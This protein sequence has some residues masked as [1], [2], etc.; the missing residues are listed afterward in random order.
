MRCSETGL[1]ENDLMNCLHMTRGK[2][3]MLAV[4]I[5][6]LALAGAGLGLKQRIQTQVKELFRMN[7]ELQEEGY[8]MADFEFKMMGMAYWLDHGHY[9]TA[10]TRLSQ[11][12]R[13]LKAKEGLV[14]VPAFS[15]KE[16]EL[17][18]Y[19]DFQNPKTGAFMDDTFPYCTYNEITENL[20][21]LL[22]ALAKETGQPL[23]LKY[24][25]KYLD[26]VNTP[27]K[28]RAF[29]DDTSHVG[30]VASRFPN[31]TFVLARSMLSFA[32]G[33]DVITENN[34]YNFSPEWRQALLQWF[35]DNQDSE[36]G[37]WGP[38][39][40][41]SG[42]LL[43]QDLTNTASVLKAFVDRTGSDI[44]ET[45][46]LRHRKEMARTSL[47]LLA[48]PSPAEQDLHEWHEWALKIGKGTYMLTRYLWKDASCEEKA[49]AKALIERF[50]TISFDMY[51]VAG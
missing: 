35:Y 30:W 7:K 9:Y 38:R 14:K 10:I 20:L 44:H 23:R 48:E 42:R 36:T 11:Y 16:Q 24:P 43:R 40:K 47:A 18:F 17:N 2:T 51:Y 33:E 19:L 8:Y 37:F 25:L 28:L 5:A 39:S 29:L 6:I 13:Q 31:T 1:G 49:E 22:D 15:N 12:H 26:A 50:V 4:L 32:N 46:P 21:A 27:G 45:F 34:L 3:V 41:Y